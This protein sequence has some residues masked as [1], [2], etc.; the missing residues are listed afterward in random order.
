MIYTAGDDVT[1]DLLGCVGRQRTGITIVEAGRHC[2]GVYV[3][4]W[5]RQKL[6]V[7]DCNTQTRN[8]NEWRC[9]VNLPDEK[10]IEFKFVVHRRGGQLYVAVL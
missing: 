3:C 10:A 7:D 8:A 9:K 6:F 2:Y 1:P 5:R 4:I